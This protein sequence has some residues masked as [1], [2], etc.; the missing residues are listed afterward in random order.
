MNAQSI[1][2]EFSRHGVRLRAEGDKLIAKPLSAVTPELREAVRQH[3]AALL[4]LLAAKHEQAEI[5]R[6]ARL[7]AERREADRQASRGYD[8]DPELSE[9]ARR[10]RNRPPREHRWLEAAPRSQ[11]RRHLPALRRGTAYRRDYGR[12]GGRQGRR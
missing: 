1:L 9:P 6:I 2:A 7:D 4:A 12:P 11:H 3:K 5:D 10:G 8:F